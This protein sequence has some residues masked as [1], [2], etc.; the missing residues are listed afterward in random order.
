VGA[1]ALLVVPLVGGEF[2][3]DW[4]RWLMG[5]VLAFLVACLTVPALLRFSIPAWRELWRR[6][7]S[8]PIAE[9]DRCT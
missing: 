8:R 2:S 9:L 3:G 5:A 4:D 7:R 1:I 6:W